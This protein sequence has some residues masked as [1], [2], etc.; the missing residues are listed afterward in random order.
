MTLQDSLRELVN[1][2]DVP[3]TYKKQA[4]AIRKAGKK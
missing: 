2:T 1:E 3:D 4:Q